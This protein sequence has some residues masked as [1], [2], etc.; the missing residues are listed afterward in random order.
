M[1]LESRSWQRYNV[2]WLWGSWITRTETGSAA[3]GG[4]DADGPLAARVPDRGRE[5]QTPTQAKR[6]Q[7]GNG[8]V[9]VWRLKLDSLTDDQ[10]VKRVVGRQL[11]NGASMEPGEVRERGET[12]EDDESVRSV[13]RNGDSIKLGEDREWAKPDF[14]GPPRTS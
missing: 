7:D 13:Q 11:R 10:V 2:C 5:P 14:L 12:G 8:M 4:R 9:P 3:G 6:R 1:S